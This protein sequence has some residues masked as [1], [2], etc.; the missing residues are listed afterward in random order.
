MSIHVPVIMVSYSVLALAVV[1]AHVLLVAM[2]ATP[3]RQDLIATIDSLHYWYIHVG[4]ILLA[5]GIITGS[6]WA[7]SSWGRYWGWDP[8][9]VWSL[10]AFVG[11]L[12][13]LHRRLDR[14][15]TP[16]WLYG[17]GALLGVALF[18]M[19][20]PKLAPLTETKL[21]ALAGTLASMLFFVLARGRFAIAV[22]S[23][24]AFWLIV[25]TYVGVNYVL[26]T[27]LHSY[28]FGT[29]AV[30]RYLFWIGG[31]DLALVMVCT[32]VYLG[33]RGPDGVAKGR[34][35]HRGK[36]ERVATV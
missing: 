2:A 33:R 10:V 30:V 9:E 19:V 6:M 7:A 26:G 22:K 20:A 3:R 31:L 29:G 25:M 21:L 18:A 32:A 8:K 35:G 11:Y 12:A 4:A 27:G 36:G 1:I 14:T 23:I 5:A 24:L 34:K 13:I 15:T 16:K 17:L 28:G